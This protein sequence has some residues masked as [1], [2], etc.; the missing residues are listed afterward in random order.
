M[1]L[2]NMYEPFNSV[3]MDDTHKSIVTMCD[4]IMIYLME[5]CSSNRQKVLA[6]EGS[7]LPKI[8]K[9]LDFESTN[10]QYWLTRFVSMFFYWLCI[11][12]FL[13]LDY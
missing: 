7:V 4:N 12:C 6:W 10:T 1:S 5:R 8:K 9:R 2:N 13:N 11:Y 3:I